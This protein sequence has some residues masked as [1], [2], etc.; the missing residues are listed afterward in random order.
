MNPLVLQHAILSYVSVERLH[1]KQ[2]ISSTPMSSFSKPDLDFSK[3]ESQLE[4]AFQTLLN[5]ISQNP[6]QL[7]IFVQL[8]LAIFYFSNIGRGA[9]SWT[10]CYKDQKFICTTLIYE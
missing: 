5:Y 7:A 1:S 2:Q 10:R 4:I 6:S 9:D 8:L 3:G